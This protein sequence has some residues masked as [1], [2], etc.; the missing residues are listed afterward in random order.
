M[1]HGILGTVFHFVEIYFG[2]DIEET[3][4]RP[5]LADEVVA[6]CLHGVLTGSAL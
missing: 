6:F 4:D 5:Q 1:A 2:N 3:A